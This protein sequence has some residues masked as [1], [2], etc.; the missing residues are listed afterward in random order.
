MQS[1]AMD[2]VQFAQEYWNKP[3]P[4]SLQHEFFDAK[5]RLILLVDSNERRRDVPMLNRL[6]ENRQK[7]FST[8]CTSNEQTMNNIDSVFCIEARRLNA[9]DYLWIAKDKVTEQEYIMDVIIERKT[10]E[11]LERSTEDGRLYEQTHRIC[12]QQMIHHNYL[13][14]EGYHRMLKPEKKE[15]ERLRQ[16][17]SSL[18][19]LPSANPLES[20]FILFTFT[21]YMKFHMEQFLLSQTFDQ[22]QTAYKKKIHTIHFALAC[23][24]DVEILQY[25]DS[26]SV[27]LLDLY[28]QLSR[29][30]D[31]SQRSQWLFARLKKAQEEQQEDRIHVKPVTMELCYGIVEFIMKEEEEETSEGVVEEVHSASQEVFLHSMSHFPS[32]K[33]NF[34]A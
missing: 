14:L 30:E 7:F 13:L 11:D 27:S 19:I 22:F 1:F 20:S 10:K 2:F 21:L 34:F 15:V 29:V 18:R 31:A 33:F 5:Y 32:S 28:Q 24:M 3:I 12:H 23:N 6:L 26:F 17:Y 9:G 25:L 16:K 8:V 4:S